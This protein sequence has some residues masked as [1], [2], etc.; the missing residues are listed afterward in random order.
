MFSKSQPKVAPGVSH[1]VYPEDWNIQG[2]HNEEIMIATM[3]WKMDILNKVRLPKRKT[4][5]RFHL[6]I[7]KKTA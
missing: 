5:H 7:F 4:A 1:L 2:L 6:N 3:Q